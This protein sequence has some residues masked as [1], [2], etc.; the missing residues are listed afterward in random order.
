MPV[1]RDLVHREH[2]GNFLRQPNPIPN[3][4]R[5]EPR[6]QQIGSRYHVVLLMGDNLN[7]FSDVFEKS[8]TVASRI[9]AAE[10]NKSQFGTHFIVLPNSMYGDWENSI[11]EYN[12]KLSSEEKQAKRRAVLKD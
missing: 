12:F 2:A 11:Y 5:K 9:A 3:L 1:G 8:K 4:Q 6:R 10:K 7:D